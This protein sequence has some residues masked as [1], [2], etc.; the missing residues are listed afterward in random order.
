MAD[1]PSEFYLPE[2]Q[3]HN[4]SIKMEPCKLGI[5]AKGA[6]LLFVLL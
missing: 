3:Q 4:V 2:L 5:L 1:D 6:I